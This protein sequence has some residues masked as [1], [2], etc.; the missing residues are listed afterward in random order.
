MAWGI[1]ILYFSLLP[2]PDIPRVL[3]QFDDKILHVG[4]YFVSALLIY[5]GFIRFNLRNPLTRVHLGVIVIACIL[6]GSAVELLQHY[7]VDNR[8]GEWSDFFANTS[9]AAACV[10]L[11]YL[12]HGRRA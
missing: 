1:F 3:H 6:F 5:L 12:F 8:A 10:L 2:G 7:L 11:L 9:G 4:I